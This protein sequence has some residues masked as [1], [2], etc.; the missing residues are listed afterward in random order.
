MDKR[1]KLAVNK[2]IIKLLRNEKIINIGTYTDLEDFEPEDNMF[3]TTYKFW[4][5]NHYAYFCVYHNN[6]ANDFVSGYFEAISWIELDD[7]TMAQLHG[8]GYEMIYQ[9]EKGKKQK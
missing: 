3:Y 7:N 8:I 2:K 9:I 4:Y 6:T 1:V 5:K